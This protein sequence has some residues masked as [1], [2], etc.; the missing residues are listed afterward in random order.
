MA[1]DPLWLPSL[2]Y[3]ELELRKLDTL[4]VMGDGTNARGVRPGVRPG[5]P[6]LAVT[7]SGSTINVSQG[8]AGL[9]RSGQ[10]LYRAQIPATSP[11]TVNAAHATFTR[12]DL[13]YLRVWDTSVDASGLRQADA[14]YLAGTAASSPAAPSPGATEIYVPLATITVP[15]SGGGSPTVSQAI[16]PYTVAP[17]GILPVTSATEPTAGG[18]GQVFYDADTDTFRYFK[19]DGVT[20]AAVLDSSGA[21]VAGKFLPPVYK[22]F[23]TARASNTTLTA[24]PDL[25][26]TVAAN[27]VYV[28]DGNIVFTGDLPTIADFKADWTIP[29]GAVFRWSR[30]GYPVNN[31]SNL[32]TVETDHSTIRVLGTYGSATNLTAAIRGRV[33]TTNPGVITFRWAQNTSSATQTIVRGGSW[34]RLQRVS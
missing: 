6:G 1:T 16:R 2:A 31:S 29:I 23:D 25:A 4:L 3:D 27:A 8:V 34:L 9:F 19:A 26:I 14:V 30:N 5:D 18:P 12:I 32:D 13:V 33:V 24:D 17:G 28:L 15:P 21:S 7:L 10:G 22:T 11:G 20:K